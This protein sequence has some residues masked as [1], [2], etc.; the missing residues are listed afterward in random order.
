MRVIAPTSK[1]IFYTDPNSAITSP[2]WIEFY[3]RMYDYYDQV[4]KWADPYWTS[5]GKIEPS[6]PVT[7]LLAYANGTDWDPASDGTVGYFRWN[8]SAWVF[9]G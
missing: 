9:V 8:G 1:P 3:Q 6:S 4:G 2:A 7:G 5:F